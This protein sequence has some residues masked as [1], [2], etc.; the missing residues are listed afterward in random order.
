MKLKLTSKQENF[1]TLIVGGKN[2]SEAYRESYNTEYMN[3][4]SIN[5]EASLL[6][7]N[8]LITT[9]IEELRYPILEKAKISLA[10]QLSRLEA[11]SR[12][13]QIK[14]NYGVALKAEIERSRL[15]GLYDK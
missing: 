13:A 14:G 7:K 8:P 4:S 3:D 12:E 6:M 9:R 2:L 10:G 11:I 1:C 15:A 5:K